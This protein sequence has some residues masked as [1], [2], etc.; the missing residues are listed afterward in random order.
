M[1]VALIIMSTG[2]IAAVGCLFMRGIFDFPVEFFKP[3][4][5][6][7]SYK[8]WTE[9]P[10]VQK[11]MRVFL[12]THDIGDDAANSDLDSVQR[13]QE[14]HPELA[15]ENIESQDVIEA[16][17]RLEGLGPGDVEGDGIC[18][19]AIIPD[20]GQVSP[21]TV[22]IWD[23]QIFGDQVRYLVVHGEIGF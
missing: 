16:D 20:I 8:F 3:M 15:V 21:G 4:G 2:R 5:I 9:I 14:Q 11:P 1:R 17:I 6:V 19:E 23:V 12:L 7:G 13:V 18:L 10:M 22:W